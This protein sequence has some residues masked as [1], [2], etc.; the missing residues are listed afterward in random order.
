M[1]GS[2]D[3]PTPRFIFLVDEFYDRRVKLVVSAEA[4]I[5]R[6]YIG[7]RMLRL[8][9]FLRLPLAHFAV[10]LDAL[11]ETGNFGPDPVIVALD[12]VERV[13]RLDM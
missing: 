6:L 7:E 13:S 3:D 4:S 11:F 10:V 12:F 2:Y 8:D 9:E 1:G 5:Q